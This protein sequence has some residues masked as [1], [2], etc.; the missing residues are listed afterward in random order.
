MLT[1]DTLESI[2]LVA[3][4]PN[5]GQELFPNAPSSNPTPAVKALFQLNC[6]PAGKLAPN[7][8]L[9]FDMRFTVP[10]ETAPGPYFIV[11]Q[12]SYWDSYSAPASSGV[13]VT[14]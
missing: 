11:F 8:T 10:K 6:A 1:N 3:N 4:C 7:A 13:R 9:N 5:Y 12:L 14:P 2:D